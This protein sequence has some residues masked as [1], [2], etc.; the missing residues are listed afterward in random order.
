MDLTKGLE[1]KIHIGTGCFALGSLEPFSV[2]EDRLGMEAVWPTREPLLV[3]AM[4]NFRIVTVFSVSE[5]ILFH[6]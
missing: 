5:E 3:L 6:V 2:F 4:E 1:V